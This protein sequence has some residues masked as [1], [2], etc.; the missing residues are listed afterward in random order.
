MIRCGLILLLSIQ[1]C[2]APH[3]AL[4]PR[5]V[6]VPAAGG[7][8]P[9]YLFQESF[10]GT[11]Y[12]NSWTED[13]GSPNEDDTTPAPYHGTHSLSVVLDNRITL[14]TTW[15]APSTAY[16]FFAIYW[17][18]DATDFVVQGRNGTTDLWLLQRNSDD[19]FR[20][21]HG[22]SFQNTAS[23]FAVGAWVYFWLDYTAGGGTDGVANVYI[24]TTTTKPGSP[25]ITVSN[26]TAT[27]GMT[28]FYIRNDSNIE[29]NIDRI[30]VDDVAIGN[31]P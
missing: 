16:C 1:A 10:E 13:L 12:E 26:G 2:L 11:G 27:L 22:S 28:Q 4:L 8:G 19:T 6:R 5:T 31:A 21:Y 9:T 18:S 15:T 7:A 24:S 14:N 30:L 23:T 3:P 29:Y 17:T 25:T 20:L